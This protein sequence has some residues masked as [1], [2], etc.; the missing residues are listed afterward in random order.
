VGRLPIKKGRRTEV[1][2]TPIRKTLW[3]HQEGRGAAELEKRK[4]KKV[5]ALLKGGH[6]EVREG[7]DRIESLVKKSAADARAE[8]LNEGKKLH[9]FRRGES[10]G[11]KNAFLHRRKLSRKQRLKERHTWKRGLR[12]LLENGRV[13]GSR[14]V[15]SHGWG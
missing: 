1:V 4:E 7:G 10:R 11:E 14:G 3:R 6:E 15:L 2:P 13:L 8:R 12:R 5:S 9:Y